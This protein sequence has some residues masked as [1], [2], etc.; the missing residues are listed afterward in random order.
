MT[1][2]IAYH[3][4]SSL[5]LLAAIPTQAIGPL[6]TILVDASTPLLGQTPALTPLPEQDAAP[7]TSGHKHRSNGVLSI[8]RGEYVTVV[9]WLEGDRAGLASKV[10]LLLADVSW[11]RDGS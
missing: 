9:G 7:S 10:S 8:A 1:R 3:V 6:A 4:K 5:L 11:Y 2:V